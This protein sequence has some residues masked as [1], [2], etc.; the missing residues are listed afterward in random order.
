MAIAL[1][2]APLIA[3][4]VLFFT[5][6]SGEGGFSLPVAAVQDLQMVAWLAGAVLL[7]LYVPIALLTVLLLRLF[8]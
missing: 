6:P 2:I 4:A 7:A 5:R 8:S 1:I 3:L